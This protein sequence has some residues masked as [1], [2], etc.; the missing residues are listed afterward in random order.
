MKRHML[1]AGLLAAGLAQAGE[2]A[3][4]QVGY[5]TG[6]TKL[7]AVP[8]VEASGF[9]VVDADTGRTVLRGQ[10]GAAARWEPAGQD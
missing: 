7:A 3:V 2:I 6:A 4:N 5:P 9:S 8:A 10:L 1:C